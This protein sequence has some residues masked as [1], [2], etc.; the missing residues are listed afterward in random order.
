M[1]SLVALR[2]RHL[3]DRN[4]G[5]ASPGIAA[6]LVSIG[7]RSVGDPS[8]EELAGYI[9]E[10]IDTCVTDHHDAA[11]LVSAVAH[12]FRDCGPLLDGGLPPAEAYEPA[13]REALERYIRSDVR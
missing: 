9:A 6:V 13:A 3:S 8:P 12:L 10:L 2:E 11:W 1:I 7:W 4:A 5:G